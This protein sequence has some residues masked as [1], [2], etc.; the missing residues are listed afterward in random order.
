MPGN[1]ARCGVDTAGGL[2]NAPATL[3][4]VRV[5]GAPI[6]CVGD[7][8]VG[9]GT[10][11]H[12]APVLAIQTSRTVLANGIP[13]VISGDLASCGHP[14]VSSSNVVIST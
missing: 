12:A 1:V 10:G 4:T 6:A 7:T 14:V 2:I 8:V 5:N 3:R 9:H 11:A 13:V